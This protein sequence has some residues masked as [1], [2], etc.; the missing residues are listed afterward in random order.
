M[1]ETQLKRKDEVLGIKLK[2]LNIENNPPQKFD[3]HINLYTL[4][5]IDGK[6]GTFGMYGS[7]LLDQ[8][9]IKIGEIIVIGRKTAVRGREFY[10]LAKR[11]M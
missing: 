5:D 11:E 7:K 3:V 6:L 10:Y 2:V 9:N 4:E 1:Y 8:N